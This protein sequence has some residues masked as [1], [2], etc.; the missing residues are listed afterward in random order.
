MNKRSKYFI[1]LAVFFTATNNL[2]GQI[3]VIETPKPAAIFTMP[4]YNNPTQQVR[5]PNIHVFPNSNPHNSNPLDMYER[6][7]WELQQRNAELYKI[8]HE[9]ENSMQNRSIRDDLPSQLGMRGTE[10]YQKSLDELSKMLRGETALNLR[11]AIFTVENAFFENRLNYSD[12]NKAV[13]KLVQTAQ[14]KTMQDGH[15]W[16]NPITKNVML[17]RAMADTLEI[18]VPQSAIKKSPYFALNVSVKEI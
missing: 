13:N 18:K 12:F 16:N 6:D 10:Y 11:N 17:F 5:Q 14:I 8:L 1:I 9:Y 4:S 2:S 7:K 15:N 3:P